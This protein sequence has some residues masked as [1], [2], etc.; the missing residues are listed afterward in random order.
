MLVFSSV[1]VC[2]AD[3]NGTMTYSKS[4]I[5][6]VIEKTAGAECIV[7]DYQE[8]PESYVVENTDSTISIPKD[9]ANAI[10][11]TRKGMDP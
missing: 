9:S 11:F 3:S 8:D 6:G 2:Y 7:K 4:Q 10:V 1:S 5:E